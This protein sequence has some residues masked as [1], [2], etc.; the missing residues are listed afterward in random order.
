[1]P[2]YPR[3]ITAFRAG[4]LFALS[5]AFTPAQALA[6][7]GALNGGGGGGAVVCL[8]ADNSL[9]SAEL[10]DFVE[11]EHF[12][13][14]KYSSSLENLS[15]ER[16]VE[17]V[18][19]RIGYIDPE[20]NSLLHDEVLRVTAALPKALEKTAGTQLVYATPSDLSKGR[21]PPMKLGC[22]VVGAALYGDELKWNGRDFNVSSVIWEKFT[23]RHKAG[24]VVHEAIYEMQRSLHARFGLPEVQDSAATRKLVAFLFSEELERISRTAEER[25]RFA[26]G[27]PYRPLHHHY[28]VSGDLDFRLSKLVAPFLPYALQELDPPIYFSAHH[29]DDKRSGFLVTAHEHKVD[30]RTN[31]IINRPLR[32]CELYTTISWGGDGKWSKTKLKADTARRSKT[33][34]FFRLLLEIP[35]ND[36]A[37]YPTTPEE[38]LIM[39]CKNA[40]DMGVGYF[41]ISCG[42]EVYKQRWDGAG[43]HG[44]TKGGL[45][46]RSIH[47]F[48]ENFLNDFHLG[49]GLSP[50][51]KDDGLLP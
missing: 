40:P 30:M 7:G 12:D 2:L 39:E 20:F 16:Q 43:V 17:T 38:N 10:V 3:E 45:P 31:K 14:I 32:R 47:K 9:K 28:V 36:G 22:Q 25:K 8:N 19:N 42:S 18:V 34:S 27:K 44:G 37:G 49:Q 48:S 6:A 46:L 26:N 41:A 23:P 50:D 29:C 33:H 4:L 5:I 15:W 21:L 24:L 1:M 11:A 35:T 13:G 51:P